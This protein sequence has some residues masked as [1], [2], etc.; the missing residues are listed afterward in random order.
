MRRFCCQR[1]VGQLWSA[2]SSAAMSTCV[3]A[4]MEVDEGDCKSAIQQWSPVKFTGMPPRQRSLHA[5]IA[6]GDCL[7]IFGG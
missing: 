2:P 5:G 7:Y 4:E 1:W 6:V 3:E